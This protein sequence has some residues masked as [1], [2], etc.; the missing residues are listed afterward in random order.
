M[1]LPGW[2][3]PLT[4]FNMN[5]GQVEKF[6]FPYL[7]APLVFPTAPPFPSLL[8][9][10]PLPPCP[11]LFSSEEQVTQSQVGCPWS[12]WPKCQT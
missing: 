1:S 4:S 12:L 7:S 3:D 9:S 6:L 8:A 10:L 11:P 5:P 2:P